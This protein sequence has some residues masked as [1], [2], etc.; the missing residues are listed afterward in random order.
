MRIAIVGA[1]GIGGHLGAML[2]HAGEEAIIIARGANLAAIR[3]HG[4]TVETQAAGTV[5]VSVAATDN[6]E[7]VGLVELIIFCVKTYDTVVA[8]EQVRPLIGPGTILLTIQNGIDNAERIAATLGV[9]GVLAAALYFSATLKA[10][11]VIA[12]VGGAGGRIVIGDPVN[13]EHSP[14]ERVAAVLRRAGFDALAHPDIRT[15]LWEK[16]FGIIC[17]S[18]SALTR[19]S[20]G[21]LMACEETRELVRGMLLEGAAVGRACG[22]AISDESVE[23]MF[24]IIT[25]LP[26]QLRPSQYYDIE[27]GRRLETDDLNGK[28]VRLG[29]EHGIATPLN[30]AIY[31]ALKPFVAGTPAHA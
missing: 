10:P 7:S 25:Q 28:I 20:N 5:N 4:L 12:K 11:G 22:A 9:D 14:A 26:A 8:A 21:P 2:A 17:G 3:E 27:A 1:G 23:R 24:G 19:L 13:G 29:R 6:P 18:L 16:L 30:F 31:A 15:A